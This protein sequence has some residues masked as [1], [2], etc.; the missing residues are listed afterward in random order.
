MVAV[1]RRPTGGSTD[2]GGREDRRDGGDPADDFPAA[3]LLAEHQ[4][5]ADEPDA[6]DRTGQRVRGR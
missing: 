4:T 3:F 2:R 1:R 5:G 6:G